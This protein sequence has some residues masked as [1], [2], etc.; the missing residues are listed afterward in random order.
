[1]LKGPRWANAQTAQMTL[2]LSACIGAFAVPD[3]AMPGQDLPQIKVSKFGFQSARHHQQIWL[4]VKRE[5]LDVIQVIHRIA[6]DRRV[7]RSVDQRLG[8]RVSKAR[9]N[10]QA[11]CDL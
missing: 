11:Q 5:T 3:Q 1:K 8:M 10:G 7:D 4:A 9:P 2:D 6:C